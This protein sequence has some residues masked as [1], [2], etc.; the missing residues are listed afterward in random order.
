MVEMRQVLLT[1]LLVWKIWSAERE[2]EFMSILQLGFREAWRKALR[3]VTSSGW[4]TDTA[5]ERNQVPTWSCQTK[6]AL[7]DPS[8]ASDPSV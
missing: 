4:K 1:K 8:V 2:S 6:G 7:A 5:G 3:I